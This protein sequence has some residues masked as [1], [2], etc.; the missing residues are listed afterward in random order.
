MT[1]LKTEQNNLEITISSLKKALLEEKE[2]LEIR[3]ISSLEFN[4]EML[5]ETSNDYSDFSTRIEISQ[6]LSSYNMSQSALALSKKNILKYEKMLKKPY[7]GR[8]DFKEKGFSKETLYIGI[9]NHFDKETFEILV[10]DWRAP[11]SNLFYENKYGELSYESPDGVIWGEVSLKRQFHIKTDNIVAFY[12]HNENVNDEV[13]LDLLSEKSSGKMNQIVETIQKKQND[14]IRAVNNDLLL[15]QGVPG[16]GKSIIALHRIA[17][18]IYHSSKKYQNSNIMILSPNDTFSQYIDAVLPELG[19]E[20]V[21]QNTYQNIIENSLKKSF[22][23]HS[24]YLERVINL[25]KKQRSIHSFK[26]SKD[27]F[28]IITG[29]LNYY[30]KNIHNYNDIFFANTTLIKGND[31]KNNII[32]NHRNIPIQILLNKYI[33]RAKSQS[34][35][36]KNNLLKKIEYIVIKH[37][38]HPFKAKSF[39]KYLLNLKED[40]LRKSFRNTLAIN[41][42][43]VYNLMKS[44]MKIIKNLFPFI[45]IP[46]N[47]FN[48]DN[49]YEDIHGIM[50]LNSL[51]NPCRTFDRFRHVVIDE[52]QDYNY[53]QYILFKKLFKNATFTILG[54][55]N[56]TMFDTGPKSFEN[57]ILEVMKPK[58]PKSVS[59]DICYR[60]TNEITNYVSKYKIAKYKPIFIRQGSEP[61]IYKFDNIKS[62]YSCIKKEIVK[63]LESSTIACIVN[64]LKEAK[65]LYNYLNSEND[66]SHISIIDNKRN[67]SLK[68]ILI[69]PVYYA[70]G[71][72]FDSVIYLKSK[73]DNDISNQISYISCS[74]ALHNLTVIEIKQVD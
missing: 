57:M 36:L 63:Y 11:I 16:S 8:V 56:Q 10:Y 6:Y 41:P 46:N 50:L 5:S 54:D 9:G 29:W 20:S 25:N 24:N 19:E 53:I 35:F 12:D 2:S 3:E 62:S 55:T 72:E 49:R 34:D 69:V 58:T 60:S 15:V 51:I 59:L 23:N 38:N 32:N 61:S 71:L 68:G 42:V 70:K 64:N 13:L 7:F 37:G 18:L 22:E 67:I 44:N 28:I 1:T 30:L 31:I 65:S 26:G 43:H 39:S 48:Q 14:I 40:I 47:L 73:L 21:L 66:L 52:S 45:N 17:Y 74:R 4:K 33:Y 27:F